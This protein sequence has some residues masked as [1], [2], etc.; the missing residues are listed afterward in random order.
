MK[1]IIFLFMA[2]IL[3]AEAK[4]YRY[5]NSLIDEDSPYLLQHAHNPVNWYAW[6]KKAFDKAKKEHKLIFLSIGYSTCH[7]CHVMERESFEDEEVAKILN[8]NYV[9]IKVDR[10]EMPSID[11]HFQDIYYL[12]HKRGG[13]WPLTV[14]LTSDAKPFFIETYIPKEPRY[15]RAGLV[16]ILK[17]FAK[18]QKEDPKKLEK[19]AVK[20]EKALNIFDSSVK[21]VKSK[22]LNSIENDFVSS[23]LEYY[24]SEHKGIGMI[25]K[26]PHAVTISTLLDIYALDKN[27]VALKMAEEMLEAMA[28]GGI[29]DQ[30]EGGFFRYSTDEKW[31]IPHYEKMLYTNAELLGDYVK[32]YK[33]TKKPLYKRIAKELV[34]FISKRF[35]KD[36]VFYSASDADSLDKKRGQK[37]EG[38]YFV[39]GYDEAKT[40]LLRAGIEDY[41]DAL[42]YLGITKRGNFKG[43]NN[44]YIN[45]NCKKPKDLP[46]VKKALLILRETKEYPFI[47]KK[48]LTSWNALY[49]KSLFEISDIVPGYKNTALNSLDSLLKKIYPHNKLYHQVLL[50]KKPK[51]DANLEDYSFMIATLIKAYEKTYDKKYLFIAEH[52]AKK[53]IVNFYKDGIWYDSLKPFKVKASLQSGSYE[54]ALSVMVENLLKLALLKEDMDHQNLAKEVLKENSVA[55]SKYPINFPKAVEAYMAFKNGYI[56]LKADKELI[57]KLKDEVDKELSYPFILY[58]LTDNKTPIACKVDSCF[59]YGDIKNIIKKLKDEI[60]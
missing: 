22:E 41:K 39:F 33:I 17:Y 23:V 1:K 52:L 27:V 49:I 35:E 14:I 38:F 24:D 25:P 57:Y 12:V 26:F 54:N 11:K 28:K 21:K 56:I 58:K 60:R 3:M 44:P 4:T 48:I 59:A 20:I 13:G 42:C 51:V 40:A 31:M 45:Q 6:S 50:G 36:G 29:Y 16:D 19:T 34:G 5:T 7:W 2:V 43:K 32:A 53:S 10:E 37:E 15:G 30:I 46:A 18:L 55:I 8:D 47:D 9:S